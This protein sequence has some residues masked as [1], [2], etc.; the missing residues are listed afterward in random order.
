MT[1]LDLILGALVCGLLLRFGT[2]RPRTN[3]T[4]AET[5]WTEPHQRADM[6]HQGSR[7]ASFYCEDGSDCADGDSPSA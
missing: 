5:V 6:Q 3:L 2:R 1:A 7:R 4:L